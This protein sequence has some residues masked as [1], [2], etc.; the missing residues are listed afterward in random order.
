MHSLF[1]AAN[2]PDHLYVL[3]LMLFVASALGLTINHSTFVCTRVNEP[4][5]T[6]VAG[7]RG[8]LGAWPRTASLPGILSDFPCA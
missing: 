4:L 7:R 2:F 1:F 8:T 3:Q 5:M 6:S